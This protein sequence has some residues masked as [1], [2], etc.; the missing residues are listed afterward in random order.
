MEVLGLK[1]L[2]LDGQTDIPERQVRIDKFNND[3]SIPIFLLSTRAGGMGINLTSA[4]TCI[5]HD[6]DCEFILIMNVPL[7]CFFI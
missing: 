3:P 5:I 1:F 4:D 6:L 7:C 2:R